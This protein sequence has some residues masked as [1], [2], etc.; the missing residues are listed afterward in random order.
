MTKGTGQNRI[1]LPLMP[2]AL[3][4]YRCIVVTAEDIVIA[5]SAGRDNIFNIETDHFGFGSH[6]K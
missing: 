1:C 6:I 5:N 3:V 4:L 2:F